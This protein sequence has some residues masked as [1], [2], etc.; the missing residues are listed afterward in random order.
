MSKHYISE[1]HSKYMLYLL[2]INLA[3]I[4]NGIVVLLV[5]CYYVNQASTHIIVLKSVPIG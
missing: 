4:A 2:N 3:H 1:K 5:L